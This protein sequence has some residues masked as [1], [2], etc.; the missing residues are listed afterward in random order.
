MIKSTAVKISLDKINIPSNYAKTLPAQKVADR[1]MHYK[2][3]GTFDREIVVDEDYNL[4]DGY[5]TY[6]ICKMLELPKVRVLRIKVS[7]TPKQLLD[8]LQEQLKK[9]G[10]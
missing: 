8:M 6:L 1:L 4:I 3:T 5:S 10:A 9:W 7:F 2:A